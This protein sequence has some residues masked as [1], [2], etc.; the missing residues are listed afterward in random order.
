MRVDLARHWQRGW[1]WSGKVSD[2][3]AAL[4]CALTGFPLTMVASLVP[5][6]GRAPEAPALLPP[7]EL[8]SEL[9]GRE[10]PRQHEEG[11]LYSI[12]QPS[13]E[14][15][16]YLELMNRARADPVAEGERLR[17]TTD[18]DV[19][20]AYAAY[21]VDLDLMVAE[22]SALS[23]APPLAM[24][25]A[26]MEA[27]RRHSE[28]MLVNDFQG[29]D[30]SDGSTLAQRV[31]AQGYP[32]SVLGENVY[33]YA[34]SVWHAHAG[35]NVDWGP[36]GAGGMQF[37]RGHRVNIH[38]ANYREVGVGVVWGRNR[39]VGPQL[40]T[41]DFGTRQ[42]ATPLL[43]GVVFYDLNGNGFYD[44]GEGIGGVTVTVDGAS[45]YAVSAN[46]GGY[47][48]PVPGDGT[49]TVRFNG[50][51]LAQE[52][53]VVEVSG[54]RNVKL[55][56]RPLYRPPEV[57][58]PGTALH[59]AENVYR[60]SP[61]GAA[62]SHQVELS[63]VV[64]FTRI[65]GAEGGLDHVTLETSPGYE[66]V[67][68]SVR[69]VGTRSF[70]LAHPAP[71]TDQILMLKAVLVPSEASE[72]H[73]QS[74]LGWASTGQVARVEVSIDDGREWGEI[75]SRFG[76]GTQGQTAF[77]SVSVSLGAFVG[78]T[79]RVRFVYDYV[80]GTYYAQTSDG[81]GW[82]LDEIGVS[83]SEELVDWVQIEVEEGDSFVFTPMALGEH[84]LRVRAQM[85]GGDFLP[86]GPLAVVQVT[87]EMPSSIRIA[88]APEMDAD[89]VTL[90]FWV[91]SGLGAT[92]EVQEVEE[93]DGTW[94][95]VEGVIIRDLGEGQYE[96]EFPRGLAP[97]RFYRVM[98]GAD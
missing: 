86:W 95:V 23:P 65:E 37:G 81:V 85:Q 63:R 71:A 96:A 11:S 67:S 58:G 1:Q 18:P 92:F 78:E 26:L 38:S 3:A 2:V 19:T 77:E 43:T 56:H 31:T 61:V 30:G 88:A 32:W 80:A 8:R 17:A 46:S 57:T 16:L 20:S 21:H 79:L 34:R 6:E 13:G 7:V 5:L 89:R 70:H 28:D 76:T 27:A 87:E 94:S 9:H 45:F 10:R 22:F 73:F 69:A 53:Q 51:G 40:V 66:V 44:V 49:Y 83:D 50:S 36:G 4:I 75:W 47:A 25:A 48:V 41:Q 68:T 93:I 60:F 42:G 59:D 72:L 29:H 74:R 39:T 62:V 84:A 14:E 98:A 64:P 97:Q 52:T 33:S 55:D 82:Y 54:L 15:Q 12:G 35:F 90:R 24:N 91:E